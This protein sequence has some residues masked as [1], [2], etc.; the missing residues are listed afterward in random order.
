MYQIDNTLLEKLRKK[1]P[2]DYKESIS[3]E[4]GFSESYIYYVITGKRKNE[5]IIKAAIELAKKSQ[6][7]LS[8]IERS[9]IEL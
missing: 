7:D 5:V 3:K 4:T 9:I 6:T 1:L 8:S 2:K